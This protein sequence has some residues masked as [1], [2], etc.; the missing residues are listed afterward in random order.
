MR[1]EVLTKETVAAAI[2]NLRIFAG[3]TQAELSRRTIALDGPLLRK[4]IPSQI[5]DFERARV[6]PR[7]EG[8]LSILVACGSNGKTLNLGL[9][10]DALQAALERA[11]EDEFSTESHL[12]RAVSPRAQITRLNRK[13]S[14]IDG[15]VEG[16]EEA[17][18][19]IMHFLS[20][21]ECSTQDAQDRTWERPAST[22]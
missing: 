11:E 9:F 21:G 17:V 19:E 8:F 5:S 16:L 13:V 20:G 7:L 2:R 18:R 12:T 10:E 6:L 15:R 14:K 22:S 3:L 4:V 1:A